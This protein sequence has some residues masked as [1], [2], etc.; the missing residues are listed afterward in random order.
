VHVKEELEKKNGKLFE[1]EKELTGQLQKLE[2]TFK[3]DT[4]T[5]KDLHIEIEKLKE[6]KYQVEKSISKNEEKHRREVADLKV[7][8][9]GVEE[10][11]NILASQS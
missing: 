3:E 10:E 1:R 2:K 4:S 8:L 9:A 11:K 6:E 5:S 7:E